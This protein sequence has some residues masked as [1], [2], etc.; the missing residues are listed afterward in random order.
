MSNEEK[1]EQ[2]VTKANESLEV[3]DFAF[4]RMEGYFEAAKHVIEQYGGD[5]AELGLMALRIE[6]ISILVPGILCFI[7]FGI[8]SAKMLKKGVNITV[9]ATK[10]SIISASQISYTARNPLQDSLMSE[11]FGSSCGTGKK[12]MEDLEGMDI[13]PCYTFTHFIYLSAGL[14][15]GIVSFINIWTILDIWA[16]AGIVYPEVYAVHKFILN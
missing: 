10:A 3:A 14:M 11:Y 8:I 1:V 6:A 2:I 12:S 4:T 7:G 13:K 5:V 9:E 15:A 16:W